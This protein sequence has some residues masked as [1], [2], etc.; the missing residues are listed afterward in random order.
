MPGSDLQPILWGLTAV[1]VVSLLAT[2]Y[3]TNKVRTIFL[4]TDVSGTP[5]PLPESLP[6]AEGEVVTFL[7]DDRVELAGVFL[8]ARGAEPGEARPVVIFSH[9]VGTGGGAYER[10]VDW[11]RAD[12]YH[13]FAFDHRGHG[14]S[15]G[16]SGH[17]PRQWV[18]RYEI[19][20]LKG[21][22]AHVRER[23]EFAPGKIVLF[24]LSRGAGT[25]VA[26]AHLAPDVCAVVADSLF[27]NWHTLL[28]RSRK[29]ARIVLRSDWLGRNVPFFVFYYL[30][31][32]TML[33]SEI[34]DRVPYSSVERGLDRW[35]GRP[36][37]I[38]HGER[39][40]YISVAQSR[41]LAQRFELAPESYLEVAR[42][43]HND[44]IIA[45]PELYQEFVTGFLSRSLGA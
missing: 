27:T 10:H 40:A 44:A 17:Q 22:I 19:A 36:L 15:Q 28:E 37:A 8:L 2:V 12:G 35:K 13:I 38:V 41:M 20:D 45:Q 7:A 24:G 29:W 23:P 43:R 16:L 18:T 21:A 25:S 14:R 4:G 3:Y 9:A 11:L 33:L 32:S 30:G 5:V 34:C 6:P 42:A 1:W 39:D 31:A 26:T